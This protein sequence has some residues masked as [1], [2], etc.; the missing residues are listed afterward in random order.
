[1]ILTLLLA[2]L[3]VPGLAIAQSAPDVYFNSFEFP[4]MRFCNLDI[5]GDGTCFNQNGQAGIVFAPNSELPAVPA[6]GG[7]CGGSAGTGVCT[8]INEFFEGRRSNG[9]PTTN[10]Q[11]RG[12][13]VNDP[14]NCRNGSQ[15]C[16]RFDLGTGTQGTEFTV[17][18]GY[19]PGSVPQACSGNQYPNTPCFSYRLFYRWYV[20][21]ATNFGLTPLNSFGC[22][23]KY[24]YVTAQAAVDY[25]NAHPP[26]PGGGLGILVFRANTGNPQRLSMNWEALDGNY[27]A[28][29]SP[30]FADGLWHEFEIE[31]DQNA[32]RMRAWLDGTL[33]IDHAAPFVTGAG[34]TLNR[35]GMYINKNSDA[36]GPR[37]QCVTSGATSFWVDDL[38]VSTQRIGGG[39]TPNAPTNLRLIAEWM[40]RIWAAL[41]TGMVA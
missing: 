16:V 40:R 11:G 31:T 36:S 33:V 34:T 41:V 38:A 32:Q 12:S 8:G 1:M 37:D 15:W 13:I 17:N 20:K 21:W 30:N 4:D 5:T 35:W 28:S 10:G 26:I 29:S 39:A 24:L 25:Y 2:L 19:K 27:S 7:V 6:N 18:T 14:A 22:Q 23:G 3:L 9:L